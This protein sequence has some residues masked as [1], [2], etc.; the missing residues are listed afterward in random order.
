MAPY[1]AQAILNKVIFA[2][3][4]ERTVL[5][6]HSLRNLIMTIMSIDFMKE[7]KFLNSFQSTG[8]GDKDE[9]RNFTARRNAPQFFQTRC[10][11]TNH[12][13]SANSL[14][15]YNRKLINNRHSI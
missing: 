11:K 14:D 13:S 6:I 8:D 3:F 5:F 1:E 15:F 4:S 10:A 12:I 7:E 9:I 2:R